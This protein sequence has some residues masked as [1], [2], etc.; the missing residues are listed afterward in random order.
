MKIDGKEIAKKIL[1]DLKGK[2]LLLKKK[3][4][5]PHLAI[6]LVGND[7]PSIAYVNQKKIKGE[8]IGAKTTIFNLASRIQNSELNEL[9]N[10]LNNDNN[11]S[12]IIVQQPLPTHINLKEIT[13]AITPAKDVDGFHANSKFQMP[14][15][16][17]VLRILE[18]IFLRGVLTPRMVARQRPRLL[19]G[20]LR[21]W[22]APKNAVVIGK[23]ETGGKPI[24][25]MFRKINIEPIV[26]DSKTMNPELLTKNSD[27]IISAVGRSNVVKPN[28]I[29]KGVVLISIGL[30]KGSDG[31][32]HGD[33]EESEIKDIA[34]FYT[35][36]PGGVGPVNVTMLLQNLVSSAG[37][38]T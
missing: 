32:L 13:Q 21:K 28:T 36:T 20:E 26:I 38:E 10:K 6:I 15:A 12:G 2:V 5:I 22:L 23:G 14:I 17:A 11:I 35:P 3:G 30:H 25:E 7:P 4:I 37:N 34:S 1:A 16:M 31:K 24:I 19:R 18:E 9:I 27:I 29:K 33:Y 8:R